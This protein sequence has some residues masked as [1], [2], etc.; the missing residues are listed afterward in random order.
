M[1][2][3]LASVMIPERKKKKELKNGNAFN[4]RENAKSVEQEKR[5]KESNKMMND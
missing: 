3:P 2:E 5:R 1:K 4:K